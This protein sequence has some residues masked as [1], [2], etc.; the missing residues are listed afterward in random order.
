VRSAERAVAL[1]H[2]GAMQQPK[3]TA[4]ETPNG[5]SGSPPQPA[6]QTESTGTSKDIAYY[7]ETIQNIWKMLIRINWLK[8]VKKTSQEQQS[9]QDSEE[10]N[11]FSTIEGTLRATIDDLEDLLKENKGVAKYIE[12]A[13]DNL[14][15]ALTELYSIP[16]I[17]EDTDPLVRAKYP[18]HVVKCRAYLNN[19]ANQLPN[20]PGTS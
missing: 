11:A 15:L 3:D 16:I 9:N 6:K 14:N 19:A 20:A 2:G 1:Y 5:N 17:A 18:E 8:L 13:L 10:T 4:E 7:K 12:A